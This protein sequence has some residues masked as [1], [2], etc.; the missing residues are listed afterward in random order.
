VRKIDVFQIHD[1]PATLAKAIELQTQGAP[2][3]LEGAFVPLSEEVYTALREQVLTD[4]ARECDKNSYHNRAHTEGV[5]R[6]FLELAK[7]AGFSPSNT[8]IG[9]IIALFHDYGHIGQTVRQEASVPV[10]RKDLSNEEY[11]ALMVDRF[12]ADKVPKEVIVS[13]QSG[14]LGTSFGQTSGPY[15]RPYKPLN[16]VE[17]LIAFADI[18]NFTSSL[19]DWM[20]EN[21]NVFREMPPANLPKRFDEMIFGRNKFLDYVSSKLEE[22]AL[23]LGSENTARYQESLEKLR[24][25][26]NSLETKEKYEPLYEALLVEKLES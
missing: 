9:C 1:I 8:Q 16:A 23:I 20:E 19:D 14:I 5:E 7:L 11:S 6:R 12:L 13:I 25:S 15:A 26:V 24:D 17:K 18:A 2:T 4:I 22:V 21:F 10:S 3:S